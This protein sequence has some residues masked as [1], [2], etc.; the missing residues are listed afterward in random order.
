MILHCAH[1]CLCREVLIEKVEQDT[2]IF[3]HMY[4]NTHR[5]AKGIL[6]ILIGEIAYFFTKKIS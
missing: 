3:R 6:K 5:N 1:T 4:V 2:N